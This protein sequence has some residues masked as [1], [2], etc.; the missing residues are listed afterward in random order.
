MKVNATKEQVASILNDYKSN[1]EIDPKTGELLFGELPIILA[2][3]EIMS[4]IYQELEKLVGESASGVMKR[5]GKSYGEKFLDL[6]T[7]EQ[8]GLLD[9]RELLYQFV[10]AETQAIGWGCITI[11]DDGKQVVISSKDGLAS[12]RTALPKGGRAHSMD[13]YFLGYFEGFLSK[14]D[15]ES[16]FGEESECVGKGDGQCRMFF[17]KNP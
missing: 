17:R 2:R 10:C 8:E 6:I 4:N 14:L 9:D 12:G 7:E 15:N 16:Y 3:A 5:L 13:S 11:E 1:T